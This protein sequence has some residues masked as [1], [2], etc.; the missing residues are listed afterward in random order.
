MWFP[1]QF[2]DR[3]YKPR[4]QFLDGAD[5]LVVSHVGVMRMWHSL[6]FIYYGYDSKIRACMLWAV[7]RQHALQVGVLAHQLASTV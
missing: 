2:L 4:S 3:D 1:L 6:Q 5:I 7:S